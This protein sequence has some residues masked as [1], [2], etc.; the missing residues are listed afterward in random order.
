MSIALLYR[1]SGSGARPRSDDGPT[2]QEA[3]RN[4]TALWFALFFHRP[5]EL[6]APTPRRV[7]AKR[8]WFLNFEARART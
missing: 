6:N 1:T 5:F 7:I 2:R 8:G 3:E 4:A